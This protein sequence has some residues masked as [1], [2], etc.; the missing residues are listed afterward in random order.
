[1]D[2][3]YCARA[4]LR[5]SGEVIGEGGQEGVDSV[6]VCVGSVV[7]YKVGG[8]E[9]VV[10]DLVAS[11]VVAGVCELEEEATE[12]GSWKEDFC[13][14]RR[15]QVMVIKIGQDEVENRFD[16]SFEAS[17]RPVAIELAHR[18]VGFEVVIGFRCV[19]PDLR[20]TSS[21]GIFDAHRY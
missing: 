16:F 1:M 5:G 3:G 9:L 10:G 20:P 14:G 8:E 11:G 18:G 19:M 6:G 15:R 2:F 17:R 4:E 12:S 7:E 21:L 13:L